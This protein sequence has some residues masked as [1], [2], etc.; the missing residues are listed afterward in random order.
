MESF[1]NDFMIFFNKL[2]ECVGTFW[3]WLI[4][5]TLGEILM[6]IIIISLFLFVI[7]LFVDFKD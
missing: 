5:T 1:A 7:N 4:S 2:F 3:N 6:F